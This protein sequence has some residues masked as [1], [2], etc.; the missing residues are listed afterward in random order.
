MKRQSLIFGIMLIVLFV[1]LGF[2]AEA[3]LTA[4]DAAAGDFFGSSV[5]ISGDY[6]IV[7]ALYDDDVPNNSGSAYIYDVV[8]A[9]PYS[10]KGQVIYFK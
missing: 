7:G 9:A 5:S 3:K 10:E 6:A 2:A 4:S 8:P 1:S